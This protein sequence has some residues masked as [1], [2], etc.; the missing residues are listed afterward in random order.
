MSEWVTASASIVAH[1]MQTDLL[2]KFGR[3]ALVGLIATMMQY[4]VLIV[5]VQAWHLPATLSSGVG[6]VASAVLN[7]ALNY[8]FTFQSSRPHRS[9]LWRF[10]LVASSALLVNV[11]L[12]QLLNGRLGIQYLL[13][14]TATTAVVLLWNFVGGAFWSFAR[15]TH[16][17]RPVADESSR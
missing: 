7:Y 1:S 15:R 9:A 12:M 16:S 6:F 13:A 2:A 5:C 14:Q 3:F 17:Y 4:C 11:L 8:H 10:M